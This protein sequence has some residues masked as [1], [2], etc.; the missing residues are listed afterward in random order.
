MSGEKP[1]RAELGLSTLIGR[2]GIGRLITEE[3]DDGLGFTGIGGGG[4][5]DAG[6]SFVGTGL[7]GV[8]SRGA[9]AVE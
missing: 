2:S 6:R 9:L 3:R 7:A 8:G 5:R 4:E 1:S